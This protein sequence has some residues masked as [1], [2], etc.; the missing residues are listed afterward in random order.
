MFPTFN[1]RSFFNVSILLISSTTDKTILVKE[2]KTWVEALNYC[3]ENYNDLVSITNL[4]D[5]RWVQNKAKKA[6][7]SHIW[8]GLRYTCVLEFWFWVSDVAVNYTKWASGG[9]G[10][11]CDMSGAMDREGDHEWFRHPDTE[12][13]NFICSEF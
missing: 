8:L 4:E 11:E 12:K 5:Q 6:L 3:R 9:E 1:R 13:F 7:T 2:N 10:D